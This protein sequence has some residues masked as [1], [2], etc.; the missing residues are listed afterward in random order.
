M[1]GIVG[2]LTKMP[3]ERAEPELL[4]M[5][6][7]IRHESFYC[8]GTWVD[9]HLGVYVGWVAHKNS[10]SHGMPLYNE[11]GDT[12]LAF[13]G[14]ELGRVNIMNMAVRRFITGNP[15]LRFL[16]VRVRTV[17]HRRR[18]KH[19]ARQLFINADEYGNALVAEDGKNA[20]LHMKD[21]L[22]FTIRRNQVDASILGEIFTDNCY[23]RGLSLRDEPVIVDIGGFIGD[24]AV[25]AARRLNARKV[26]VCEP[27]PD[28]WALL[29]KNVAT[30][31]YEDRI[32]MVNKAVTDGGDVM[33]N[34]DAPSR[35]QARVSAYYGNSNVG[36]RRVPGVT[37]LRLVEDHGL[38]VIDLLKID[39]E[40][41]EYP[42]LM[43]MP[44]ELFNRIRNI[45]FECHEIDGFE[46]KLKIVK[47]RLRDEGYSLKTHG[48]L[49]SA[50]RE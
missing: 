6:K 24:F 13:S 42:I 19:A 10:F 11:R 3:R 18:F 40:G 47:Q 20:D 4:R 28:N 25:Y 34:V 39:C 21:G 30:N 32:E 26:V 16:Y 22:V 2:L 7:A 17:Y 43:T 27:S 5:V 15:I 50:S 41:G 9:E 8:A 44:T 31:H 1:P 36:R 46:A 14:G 29:T 45:V 12:V 33:M 38:D 23:V 48:S 37:L 35:G 49:I